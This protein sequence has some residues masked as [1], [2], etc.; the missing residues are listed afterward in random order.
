[1]TVEFL[2]QSQGRNRTPASERCRQTGSAQAHNKTVGCHGSP[3]SHDL[4]S[5]VVVPLQYLQVVQLLRACKHLAHA[6]PGLLSTGFDG[7]LN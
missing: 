5:Q 2:G 4:D 6:E 3:E 1:M 7:C